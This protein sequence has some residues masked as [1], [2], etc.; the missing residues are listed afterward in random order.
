MKT[1]TFFALALIASLSAHAQWTDSGTN[2]TTTD[3]VGIGITAPRAKFDINGDMYMGIGE[4]FKLYGDGNYFGQYLDALI[5]EMRDGNSTNGNTDGGF[6][7]RGHTPTDGI[8]KDWMVIKTGGR[9]G[10]G[11]NFPTENLTVSG[12]SARLAVTGPSGSSAILMGNQDS[13]G[14]NN[15]AIIQ[16]ANGNLYF[17]GGTNWNR[18]GTLS[19]TMIVA[20]GGNVGIGMGTSTP[21]SKL[22]V[23]GDIKLDDKI[24][25][26][27][28]DMLS[29]IG[30]TGD[31]TDFNIATTADD[32]HLSSGT[33][34]QSKTAEYIVNADWSYF[35]GAEFLVDA[36][37]DIS[38]RGS[39]AFN[40]KNADEI[41]MDTGNDVAINAGQG[42]N[43][44][45]E[46]FSVQAD[47]YFTG[48]VG[49]GTN[50]PKNKLSVNGTIWA[51][52]VKVSLTDAADWV[53][54][55]DYNLR[56]LEEVAVYI[57]ENKHLPEIPSAEEF[58]QNDMKVSEMTNKLL[59]KIEEL[60][61][62]T[63]EQ[64]TQLKEEKEINRQQAQH[65][66]LLEARLQ[67]LE[68]VLFNN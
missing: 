29:T 9:V 51:K 35:K 55:E 5:F 32:L 50:T 8:S 24:T 6:L 37:D 21:T 62:Y 2:T 3:N 16:A 13:S 39:G 65:V 19:T 63:I 30:Y 45:S 42:V 48:A 28:G 41:N 34:I 22:Q 38:F 31:E 46:N 20:D 59:Q 44:Q 4:G 17:G 68:N 15:P 52:E 58:R 33:S 60:T 25:F 49:I 56:P 11:T 26:D 10:I 47:S 27:N 7:F 12:N 67:K 66:K 40:I 61:L 14:V 23:V 57:K 53:F 18:G 43:I 1:I 36:S 64:E 54:E